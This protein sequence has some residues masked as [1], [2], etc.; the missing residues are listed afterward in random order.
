M[1]ATEVYYQE[2]EEHY[3]YISTP[4]EPLWF[5]SPFSTFPDELDQSSRIWRVQCEKRS[6]VA[7]Q[8]FRIKINDRPPSWLLDVVN[9]LNS[10]LALAENWDSYGAHRIS[11]DAG[12]AA[13]QVLLAVMEEKTPSP[14]IVPTPLG[15]IQLEWHK[16]GIDLEVEIT[17][18]K[19]YSILYE[20][21][22]GETE[23]YED[24]SSSYSVHNLQPLSNLIDQITRRANME[25]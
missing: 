25:E 15:G 18:S 9:S 6:S 10:L 21:E 17:P 3:S 22:T 12:L 1:T 13:I 5:G 11:V 2:Q 8:T 7:A 24:D 19:N 14:S 23:P 20:D 4:S 16:L